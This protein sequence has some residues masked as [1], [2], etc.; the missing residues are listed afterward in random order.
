MFWLIS[1]I[2]VY[3]YVCKYVW[4]DWTFVEVGDAGT[5]QSRLLLKSGWRVLTH[6]LF[7][8]SA[9]AAEYTDCI[10]AKR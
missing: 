9:G 3:M 2:Y 7:A 4:I 5:G 6:P 1:V 10:S 8:Q